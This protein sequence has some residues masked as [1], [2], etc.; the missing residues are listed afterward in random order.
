MKTNGSHV[1]GSSAGLNSFPGKD[2]A[3]WSA[4]R[5]VLGEMTP[6]E[7]AALERTLA[8][9]PEACER[10]ASVAR[11]ATELYN[12]LADDALIGPAKTIPSAAPG[13][14]VR[15]GL[16]AVVGVAA[17]VCVLA[18]A[19]LSLLPMLNP[20]GIATFDRTDSGAGSLVA[21]WTEGSAEIGSETSTS[22]MAADRPNVD[23]AVAFADTGDDEADGN[24]DSVFVAGDDYNV[25]GW[26]IAAVEK[27]NSWAPSTDE[28]REN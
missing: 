5:Y 25:P 8:S 23:E 14:S 11:L 7:I 26:M 13:R 1:D 24:D 3:E 19:G 4:L 21:I 17:A 20:E 6:D 22:G 16:W 10:V 27:G 9:D 2:E 28:I 12:A 18:A 15:T